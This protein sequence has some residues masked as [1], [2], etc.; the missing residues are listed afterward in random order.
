MSILLPFFVMRNKITDKFP[1]NEMLNI[2][3]RKLYQYFTHVYTEDNC[4]LLHFAVTAIKRS[5]AKLRH[6][7]SAG[8][9]MPR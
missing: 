5:F 9:T 8:A 7:Q 1:N 4:K 6:S 3:C 2:Y